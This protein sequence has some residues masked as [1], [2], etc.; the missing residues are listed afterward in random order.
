MGVQQTALRANSC[1]KTLEF[2]LGTLSSQRI[3]RLSVE[4]NLW[5]GE[6]IENCLQRITRMERWH[7]SVVDLDANDDSST[8]SSSGGGCEWVWKSDT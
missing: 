2:L 4:L 1:I 6:V 5:D 7:D 8:S 3:F